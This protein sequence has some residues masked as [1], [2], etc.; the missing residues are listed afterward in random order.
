[1]KKRE[2][3]VTPFEKRFTIVYNDTVNNNHFF[4][5]FY[6]IKELVNIRAYSIIGSLPS[7]ISC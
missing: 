1:M 7:I 6:S 4:E 3:T 5:K 2:I